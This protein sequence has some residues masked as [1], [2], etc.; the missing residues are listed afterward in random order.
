MQSQETIVYR[1]IQRSAS[2]MMK[3]LDIL[4]DKVYDS[5]LALQISRQ[6]LQ[7]SRIHNEAAQKLVEAKAE[8]YRSNYLEDFMQKG[9]IQYST[10]LNTSTGH[11]AEL[12]I[13][14][15]T[16]GILD[17]EKTLRHHPDAGGESAELARQ[18]LEMEEKSLKDW[19]EYL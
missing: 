16:K 8:N 7:Y 6:S 5:E 14:N 17:M 1:E 9:E 19:K 2:K 10:L 12:L 11:I 3:A 15:T 18:M 4:S 13:Q